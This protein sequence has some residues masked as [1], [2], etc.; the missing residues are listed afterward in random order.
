MHFLFGLADGEGGAVFS[1]DA[2]KRFLADPA[3]GWGLGAKYGNGA[4]RINVDG[5][6]YLHHTGGMVSFCSAMHVDAEAGVGAFASANV[7]YALNYR[8]DHV[9]TFACELMRAA[10][11]KVSTPAPKP[12]KPPLENPERFAGAFTSA[13]GDGLRSSPGRAKSDCGVAAV[14][15]RW[16]LRRERYFRQRSL[17]SRSLESPLISRMTKR[18]GCG[19]EKRNTRAMRRPGIGLQRRRPC[20]FYRVVTTTTIAGPGRFSFTPATALYGSATPKS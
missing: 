19:S 8:H 13:A 7:H 1:D 16:S 18:R 2:A 12:A 9:T 17:N 6:D 11:V 5:R 3:D 20:G 4:A 15:A 10:R 14:I